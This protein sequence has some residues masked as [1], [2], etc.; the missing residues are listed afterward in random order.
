M[1]VWAFGAVLYELLTGETPFEDP[2]K[3]KIEIAKSLPVLKRVFSHI[4]KSKPT[5]D[6]ARVL[7]SGVFIKGLTEGEF[8]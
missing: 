4:F 1:D 6:S 5:R 2:E 7:L 8:K 3:D